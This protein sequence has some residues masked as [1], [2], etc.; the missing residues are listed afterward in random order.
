VAGWAYYNETDKTSYIHNGSG[1]TILAKDGADG[2]AGLPKVFDKNNQFIGYASATGDEGEDFVIFILRPQA[3]KLWFFEMNWN[4]TL[5]MDTTVGSRVY[6]DASNN[7]YGAETSVPYRIFRNG[8]FSTPLTFA[9]PTPAG[10]G[11]GVSITSYDKYWSADGWE[12]TTSGTSPVPLFPLKTISWTEI[13][14]TAA[15]V[16][17]LRIQLQ[18]PSP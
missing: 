2:A 8:H 1:W 14:M 13:G 6:A 7:L 18:P 9:N 17:P 15:P 10:L 3:D 16:G 11:G 4:G 12:Y 5:D